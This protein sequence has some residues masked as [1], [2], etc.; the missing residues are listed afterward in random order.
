MRAPWYAL[1]TPPPP[2]PPP[3]PLCLL[4]TTLG[5]GRRNYR[6]RKLMV[7]SPTP[8]STNT[9][10]DLYPRLSEPFHGMVGSSV[11]GVIQGREAEGDLS[12]VVPPDSRRKERPRIFPCPSVIFDRDGRHARAR[13]LIRYH[14]SLSTVTITL[15]TATYGA[16]KRRF[17]RTEYHHHLTKRR[18]RKTD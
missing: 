3:R 14:P 2:S 10:D 1:E 16:T 15:I 5:E 12:R 7:K 11:S 18:I 4:A 6:I 9:T 17:R 13:C 8:H